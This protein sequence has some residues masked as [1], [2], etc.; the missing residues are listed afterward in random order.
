M[1]VIDYTL[2]SLQHTGIYQGEAL[3]AEVQ[4]AVAHAIEVAKTF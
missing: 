1:G 3:E 2:I 4:K